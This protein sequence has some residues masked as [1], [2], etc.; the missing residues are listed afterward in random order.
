MARRPGR[1]RRLLRRP[2]IPAVWVDANG[3]TEA[4]RAVLAQLARAPE[5]GLNLSAFALPRRL[6]GPLVPEATAEAEVAVAAAVVAYAEQASGSRLTPRRV[7]R[8]VS[9]Q[10]SVADPG[11][12]LAETAAAPDPGARLADFNPPQK[13]Y[14]ALRETS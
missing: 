2:R 11:E 5:D 8:L 1:D 14:R 9:A 12:A 7:S 10:P 4:G 6:V 3:L 13:G